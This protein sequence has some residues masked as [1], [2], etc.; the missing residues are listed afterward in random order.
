MLKF[1]LGCYKNP[2]CTALYSVLTWDVTV[3]KI[4]IIVS[5]T[6]SVKRALLSHGLSFS[7]PLC[8]YKRWERDLCQKH[9]S[10]AA[11]DYPWCSCSRP[12]EFYVVPFNKRC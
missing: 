1:K 12:H 11:M 5:L 6:T 9:Q 2:G 3:W 10:V 4:C 8:G 7:K